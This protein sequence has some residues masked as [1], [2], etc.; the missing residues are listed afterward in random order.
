[1]HCWLCDVLDDDWNIEIPSSNALVIRSRHK[2][3][4][5]LA[6]RFEST[7]R[8]APFALINKSNGVDR[9]EMLIVFLSDIARVGI[10]LNDL[11]VVHASQKD[12]ALGWI[13]VELDAIGQLLIRESLQTLARFR[14]PKL[15]LSIEAGRDK[16]L[17]VVRKG[18]VSNGLGVAHESSKAFSIVVDV[19]QLSEGASVKVDQ[20]MLLF[21]P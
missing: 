14:V 15:H 6:G 16:A 9:S 12:V 8:N 10:P 5:V 17:A 18:N 1:V 7:R 3:V 20:Q 13:R 11:L 19:P 21:L 4:E 2:A